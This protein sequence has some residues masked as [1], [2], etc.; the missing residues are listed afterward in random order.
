MRQ[1]AISFKSGGAPLEGIMGFP[2]GLPQPFPAVVVCHPYPLFDGNMDNNVVMAV[3]RSLVETGFVTFRFNF[4]GMGDSEGSFTKGEKEQG[5]V[6]AAL[7]LL[8]RWP[9]IDKK[10]R[11]LAGYS[12]GASVI[13]GGLSEY[14]TARALAIISP[15]LAAVAHEKVARDVRPKRFIVGDRDGLVPHSSLSEKIDALNGPVELCVVAG[16]DHSWSGQEAEVAS[17]ATGFFVDTLQS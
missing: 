5:D 2:E 17:Q 7:S 10:R 16:A 14:K 4:R 11:G 1:T 12:F 6:A 13:L 9:G 3:C 15:P 8:W